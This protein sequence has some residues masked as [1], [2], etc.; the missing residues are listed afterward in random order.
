V[1]D[2]GIPS[3]LLHYKRREEEVRDF[4][5]KDLG[6]LKNILQ[7]SERFLRQDRKRRGFYHA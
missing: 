7:L 6:L 1:L 5:H 4:S 3:V 2:E